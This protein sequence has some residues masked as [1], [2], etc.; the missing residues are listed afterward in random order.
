MSLKVSI[1]KKLGEFNLDIDFETGNETLALFGESGCGKSM[2]LKCIAGIE[3]P[4]YGKIVLNGRILFDS[5]KK[6]DL[7]P[8][9]RKVGYLFQQYALFPHMNV[10]KNIQT[11]VS[12]RKIEKDKLIR[13]KIKLFYLDGLEDKHPWELSGGQ[14]QRVALA[15]I[16]AS[17]PEVLLLDEPFSALD[18]YLKWQLEQELINTLEAYAGNSIFVSHNRDEVYRICEKVSIINNGKNEKSLSVKELFENPKSLSAALLT[19][20]KNFSKIE[21]LSTNE[22]LA[23][24]WGEKITVNKEISDSDKYIGVRVHHIQLVNEIEQNT[25][26]CKIEKSIENVFS[27]IVLL[28]PMNSISNSDYSKIRIEI[29]KDIWENIKFETEVFIKIKHEDIMIL[30]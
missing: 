14:Q 24:D 1:K 23:L 18:S 8:R 3:K 21:K 11:A 10:Y 20:C 27:T 6:I 22:V 5:E 30:S 4:D 2:T 17:N 29:S 26:R 15:R 9:E 19:G 28:R 25:I 12:D 13:E 16:F 7:P